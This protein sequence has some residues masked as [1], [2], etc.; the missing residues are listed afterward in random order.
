MRGLRVKKVQG[1]KLDKLIEL[2]TNCQKRFAVTLKGANLRVE[3]EMTKKR[4]LRKRNKI[5]NT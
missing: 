2:M 5:E 4:M 3:I 1:Q